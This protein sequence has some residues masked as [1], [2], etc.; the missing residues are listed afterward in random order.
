MP[1][2][3]T[4]LAKLLRPATVADAKAQKTRL[5]R[6]VIWAMYQAGSEARED[7]VSSLLDGTLAELLYDPAVMAYQFADDA[8]FDKFLRRRLA[9]ALTMR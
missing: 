5:N 8:E 7:V 2:G 1:S 6:L 3:R 9:K 4:Q